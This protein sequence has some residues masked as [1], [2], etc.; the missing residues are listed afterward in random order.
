MMKSFKFTL[1]PLALASF[2]M[3]GACMNLAPRYEQPAL[4][5]PASVAAT[6]SAGGA[7]LDASHAADI[8]WDMLIADE[9]LKEVIRLALD[10]NRDLRVAVANVE[11]A[12]ATWRVE[13]A[14]EFPA[15]KATGSETREHTSRTASS[16]GVASTSS[17][18][19]AQL[20]V[21]AYEL[22]FFG[23]VANLSEAALQSYLQTEE[24]QRSTRLT[25][26]SS[27]A[28]S[29]LTLAADRQ[30]LKLAQDTLA[31]R[32][33]TLDT[34][35]RA[36]A[37]GGSSGPT[38]AA[39]QASR[40]AAR[41]SVASYSSTVEQDRNALELLLGAPLPERLMPPQGLIGDDSRAA[42]LLDVPAD[43]SSELLLQRPDVLAAE[44]TLRADNANIGAARAAFFPAITLT[45]AGGSTSRSLSDLFASG[46]GAWSFAPSISLPIFDGGSNRAT[47]DAKKAQQSADIATYEKTIQTAFSEVADALAVRRHISEQLDAQRAQVEALQK[48]LGYAQALQAQGSGSALDVLD[49]QRTLF[50]AQQ[51][52]TTLRL[53][54]Q[55][56][57]ITLY[58]VL[59]GGSRKKDDASA[60]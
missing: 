22:D 18:W 7:G 27:V 46:S 3:L 9:R 60:G 32:E 28:S 31:S 58:K 33:R 41:A 10:N 8:G 1:R 6:A 24:T 49:A 44:H 53:A 12:R 11:K 52:L 57:R 45:A 20:G 42:Q 2:L 14:D 29:W 43:L 59:G 19:K 40:E 25:L 48:S 39:A 23:R 51:T 56:N 15:L 13:R 47:L 54:E 5:V 4:P 34:V 37:I 30:Q 55:T 36:H 17:T 35:Q 21:S 26:V 50:T 16:S 38:L